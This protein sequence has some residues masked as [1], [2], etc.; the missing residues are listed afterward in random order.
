MVDELDGSLAH[1]NDLDVAWGF[2]LDSFL[3]EP[4]QQAPPAAGEARDGT[5]SRDGAFVSRRC[6]RCLLGPVWERRNSRDD[7]SV[8]RGRLGRLLGPGREG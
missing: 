2:D 6:G 4:E 7:G 1:L 8:S 5:A 3:Q